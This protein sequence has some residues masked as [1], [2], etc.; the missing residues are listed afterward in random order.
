MVDAT[1]RN[2]NPWQLKSTRIAYENPW[3]KI[4]EDS[5]VTPTGKDGIYGYM[6]SRDS[7]I[8]VV[9]NDAGEV[10]MVRTFRYPDKTWNWELS[11]GGGDG[12]D[13]IDASK[14]ELEEETGIIASSWEVLG[15]TS[16][17]DGLM[18]EKM[19]TLLA[20][21]LQFNG[22]KETSD[23][24]I[25]DAGF[26]SPDNIATMIDDGRLNDGQSITALFL[27]QHWLNKQKA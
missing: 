15:R 1:N 6:E 21:D 16:V 24:Q 14:R 17:C 9:V 4:H 7:V 10:Y 8:V 18:T 27:Y 11:G 22:T 2:D 20:R 23:E 12:Q 19:T 25:S 3:I 5:V 26:F 13:P